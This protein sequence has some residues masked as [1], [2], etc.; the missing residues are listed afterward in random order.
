M[1][2]EIGVMHFEGAMNQKNILFQVEKGKK[3]N[4]PLGLPDRTKLCLHHNVTL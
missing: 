3:V 1:E 2:A 4:L